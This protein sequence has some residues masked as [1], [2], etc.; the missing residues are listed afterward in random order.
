MPPNPEADEAFA[1]DAG[2]ASGEEGGLALRARALRLLARRDH[3]RAELARKLAPHAAAPE[4][5]EAL[6]DALSAEQLLSDS[7]YAGQRAQA[8]AGR[9]G[10]A[11]LR[12]E[13]RQR[14]VD[15][16]TADTALAGL[17]DETARAHAIWLKKYG[18]APGDATERARQIRFLQGRGFSGET[19]RRVLRGNLEDE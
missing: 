7:R 2:P 5:V 11:R 8:R 1:A 9:Y 10:N 6:L 13:L 18:Q 12:Q 19:I 16:A 3:C 14:G 17:D 4:T 15:D